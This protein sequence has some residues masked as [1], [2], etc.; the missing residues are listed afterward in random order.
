M[1]LKAKCDAVAA[2]EPL[3]SVLTVHVRGADAAQAV[4]RALRLAD[5]LVRGSWWSTSAS[6]ACSGRRWLGHAMLS[7]FAAFSSM[8]VDT[9]AMRRRAQAEGIT[10]AA[11]W[12]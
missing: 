4:G 11:M 9:D 7:L 10:R 3:T 6:C 12:Q 1:E 2:K 5:G 8:L